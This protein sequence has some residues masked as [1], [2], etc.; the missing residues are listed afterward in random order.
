MKFALGQNYSG[1]NDDGRMI[2]EHVAFNEAIRRK[3]GALY[4]FPR[5]QNQ[6]PIEHTIWGR[7][8]NHKN[9]LYKLRYYLMTP[10]PSAYNL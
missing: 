5:L 8:L 1:H 9:A 2:C 4:I 7:R 6:A 3:G 10:S